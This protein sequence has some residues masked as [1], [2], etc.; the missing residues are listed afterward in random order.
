MSKERPPVPNMLYLHTHTHTHTHCVT[1]LIVMMRS[2]V[3]SRD[4]S[5][6]TCAVEMSRTALMLQPPR[7]IT[8]LI[9]L[10]GTSSRFDLPQY[11]SHR[12]TS[13]GLHPSMHTVTTPLE[14]K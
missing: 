11:N 10:A 5:I 13:Y 7:P 3:E 6:S 4:L 9:V 14:Q 12:H 8:R 1:H 2:V